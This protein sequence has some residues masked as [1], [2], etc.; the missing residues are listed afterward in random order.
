[1]LKILILNL[2][3]YFLSPDTISFGQSEFQKTNF[4]TRVSGQKQE[5]LTCLSLTSEGRKS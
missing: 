5:D 4:N 2:K 3:F 1:M